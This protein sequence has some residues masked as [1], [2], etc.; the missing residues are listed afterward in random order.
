LTDFLYEY[1]QTKGAQLLLVDKPLP[2]KFFDNHLPKMKWKIVGLP[3]DFVKYKNV[4]QDVLLTLI[5]GMEQGTIFLKRR[6]SLSRR[7]SFWSMK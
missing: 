5:T 6:D 7:G 4:P 1:A 2:A 3:S